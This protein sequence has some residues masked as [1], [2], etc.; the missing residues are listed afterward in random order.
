MRPRT[1]IALSAKFSPISQLS[2][3]CLIISQPPLHS[4][5]ISAIFFPQFYIL[6]LFILKIS[7]AYINTISI[8]RSAAAFA[9]T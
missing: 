7:K 9:A 3:K 1:G 6:V 4:K 2:A 5:Q 8:R